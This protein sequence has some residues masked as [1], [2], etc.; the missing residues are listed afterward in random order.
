VRNYQQCLVFELLMALCFLC[1]KS[2]VG[3]VAVAAAAAAATA[4]T[5]ATPTPANVRFDNSQRNRLS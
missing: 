3:A 4:A 1:G 5:A 2:E